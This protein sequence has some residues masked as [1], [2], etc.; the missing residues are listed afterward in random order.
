VY[1][2]DDNIL[3]PDY[4]SELIRLVRKHTQIGVFSAGKI[5]PRYAG[6]APTEIESYW[7]YMA[8]INL[9]TEKW[10]NLSS[11]NVLPMGA[12]MAVRKAVMERYVNLLRKDRFRKSTDRTPTS[13]AAGGDTDIGI[14]ACENGYGCGYFPDLR[15]IH[16]M[17]G[18]YDANA[19]TIAIHLARAIY[20]TLFK[21]GK[22]NRA[23]RIASRARLRAYWNFRNT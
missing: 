12:G 9:S 18:V 17:A 5:L 16:V 4:A 2:D 20:S 15:L 6:P 19:K 1:V 11:S 8:L 13:L 10:S 14:V 3:H 7:P 22:F 21:F 23:R